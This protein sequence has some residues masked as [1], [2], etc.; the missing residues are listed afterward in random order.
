MSL[1]K[2]EVPQPQTPISKK[3]SQQLVDIFIDNTE[4][5]DR[6]WRASSNPYYGWREFEMRYRSR[7][8][9]LD[10]EEQIAP[11][12]AWYLI[13]MRRRFSDRTKAPFAD[14][15]GRSFYWS[16]PSIYE[17]YMRSFDMELGG[18]TESSLLGGYADNRERFLR[19]SLIEESIASSQLEGATT[20]REVAKKMIAENRNPRNKSE[21]MILNNFK[22][23]Q[24]M[25]EETSNLPLSKDILL[26]LQRMLTENTF[27]EKDKHKAGRWRKDS[28]NIAV[29]VS[30]G[31]EEYI[32][33]IPP[34]EDD[35][36]S[37]LDSLILYANSPTE[38]EDGKFTHP[39]IKAII[40]HFWFAYIHPFAD[41]NGRMARMIF[42]WYLMKSDYWLIKYVP[43]STVI[44][45]SRTQYSNAFV[46][47]EQYDNDLTYFISFNFNKLKQALEM[48]NNHIER[49]K[50][51]SQSI[52]KL[53]DD[54]DLNERQK[55]VLHYLGG[56]KGDTITAR[57]H[58][59]FQKVS[60]LTASL[61]LKGL[62]EKKYINAEKR[63]REVFYSASEPFLSLFNR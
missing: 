53:L 47:S 52:D 28:D 8:L 41:G 32:S 2:Y 42:Y 48:F 26:E 60:W 7:V 29:I 50:K 33:H 15:S 20:S 59:T 1:E 63:G 49:V 36:P 62:L 56:N 11:H 30:E 44:K 43:I 16:K 17:S 6:L 4:E 27:D 61:D 46:F 58:A 45:S 19:Q 25:E 23:I 57:K 18:N 21:W 13:K 55:Q 14:T 10:I 31:Q 22:T 24:K 38:T 51:K 9:H 5:I 37:L 54:K 40:L 39:I 35:I 3:R 34:K 12:E